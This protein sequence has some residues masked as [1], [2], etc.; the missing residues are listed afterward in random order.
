MQLSALQELTEMNYTNQNVLLV[1][2]WVE[3]FGGAENVVDEL[4]KVFPNSTLRCSWNDSVDR[5]SVPIDESWLAKTPLRR[6][7]AL[8]LPLQP[9]IHRRLKSD[10][11]LIVCSSHLFAHHVQ[12]RHTDGSLLPKFIYAHTPARYIWEPEIDGRGKNPLV[13]AVAPLFRWLDKRRAGQATAIAA[14]SKFVQD[15]IKRSWGIDSTVIYPPVEV[16][17]SKS[18]QPPTES[19]AQILDSLPEEFVLGASRFVPYKRVDLAI[20][21]AEASGL[22]AVIAGDGPELERLIERAR[23]ASVPVQVVKSPSTN[24]LRHIYSRATVF[25]FPP[26]EDFGIMPV[27]AMSMGTPVIANKVGGGSETVRE[28]V[29]GVLLESFDPD[30]LRNAV[31]QAKLLD[32]DRIIEHAQRFSDERFR[33]EVHAW[34]S[35]EMKKR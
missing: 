21:A 10:A 20:D 13:K 22:P 15:R 27:E 7:K 4:I 34:I 6:H 30:S 23:T 8:S 29:S 26:V 35:S 16:S 5:I 32:R 24:L 19:E 18:L 33:S 31:A 14:N 3:Q 12:A 25:V 1:H 28:S 2:E 11:T 9:F 17:G